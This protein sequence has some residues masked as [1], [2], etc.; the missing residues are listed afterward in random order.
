MALPYRPALTRRPPRRAIERELHRLE[1]PPAEPPDGPP[2]GAPDGY[3]A[4]DADD[5][6]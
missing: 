4:D 6:P 5:E 2:S 3:G 1:A